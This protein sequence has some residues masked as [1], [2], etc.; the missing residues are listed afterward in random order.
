MET[1]GF[2][3]PDSAETS[4]QTI[5]R[6]S[7]NPPLLPRKAPRAKEGHRTARSAA[8][9]ATVPIQIAEA[10]APSVVRLDSSSLSE[11]SVR[12]SEEEQDV[13][14]AAIILK[15]RK[16]LKKLEVLE[17][18][19]NNKLAVLRSGTRSGQTAASSGNAACYS[20]SGR[21]LV[22]GKTVREETAARERSVG[23]GE[24]RPAS[25]AGSG[26]QRMQATDGAPC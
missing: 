6:G 20:Q 17:A 12:S 10:T 19:A 2:S 18:E 25:L 21:A 1:T 8:A 4:G 3:P 24:P 22:S 14:A 9:P 23:S 15:K 5:S 13:M 26:F 7:Y 11:V 16:E